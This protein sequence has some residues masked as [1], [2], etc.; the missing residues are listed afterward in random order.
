[1]TARAHLLF[2]AAAFAAL[3]LSSLDTTTPAAEPVPTTPGL[4][5]RRHHGLVSDAAR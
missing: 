2:A 4:P 3:V 5:E 1:M